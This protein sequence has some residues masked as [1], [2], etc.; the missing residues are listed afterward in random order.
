M[1]VI[2]RPYNLDFWEFEGTRAQLEA[3]GVIPTD[4]VWPEGDQLYRWESGRSKFWLRRTRPDGIKGPKKVWTSGDWWCVRCD[5]DYALNGAA[6][7]VLQK[8]RELAAVLHRHSPS[9][10][11]EW[12]MAWNRYWRAHED[13]AFQAFKAIFV[14]Q[15]KKPGR[16]PKTSS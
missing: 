5:Y 16:K 7:A 12:E 15:R 4:V 1:K 14:P 13:K 3:E 11:R 8:E 2:I 6:R 10:Q 9:G